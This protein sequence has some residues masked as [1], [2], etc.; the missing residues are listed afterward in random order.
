VGQAITN[1]QLEGI[2]LRWHGGEAAGHWWYVDGNAHLCVDNHGDILRVS[3][4][5]ACQPM[6]LSDVAVLTQ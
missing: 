5:G 2:G 4:G 3:L 1:E 6:S